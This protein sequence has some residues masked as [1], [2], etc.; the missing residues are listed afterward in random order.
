MFSLV[1]NRAADEFYL[2][3]IAI[4]IPKI[5]LLCFGTFANLEKLKDAQ[6]QIHEE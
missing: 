1:L 4:N 6:S 3:C 5:K 2:A